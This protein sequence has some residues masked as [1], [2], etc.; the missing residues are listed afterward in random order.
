MKLFIPKDYL[1]NNPKPPRLFLCTTGK[2]II[3]E[4]PSYDESL[5]GKWGAYSEMQFSIDRQYV[6][7]LTGEVKVH[8]TFDKAEGLRKVYVENT[9][10]FVIQDPDTTYG[11]K[12]S[13]TLSCFS[14]EYETANKYLE[15]FRVNT[16]EI[17]SKEVIALESIYGYNYTIDKDNLYKKASGE[18]DAYESYYIKDYTDNN[19][20]V[21]EQVQIANASEY[22]TYDGSTVAKTLYVKAYPNVRFY[23]PTNPKLSLLHLVF[24][25]I[26]EWK[27]GEN[28]DTTLWRK[29]RTFDE[30]RIAVYDF[31]LNDVQETFKCVVEWDTITN[32]VNFYEEAEGGITEDNTVQTRWETD[33]FISREN[34]ANEININY[35]TDDIKT[36]LKVSGADNLDIREV[37]LGKN[38]ILNLDY[39]HTPDWME[40]DLFERYDDYLKAVEE[41]TPQYTEAMQNWVAAYNKWHDLMNAVPAEGNVVLVGDPFEKLYCVYGP[42]D[43]AYLPQTVTDSDLDK[44]VVDNLYSLKDKTVAIDKGTLKD[45]ETFAVQGYRFVYMKAN[46]NFKCLEYMTTYNERILVG[47]E[48]EPQKGKLS[49]YH[50]ID[51]TK[52]TE[53]DNILL[54]LK[55]SNS[56]IATIRIYN[57]GT[58]TKPEYIIQSII[59]GASSGIAEKAK[60]YTMTQWVKGELT[61]KLMGF[62][63]YTVQYIGTMGAYFVLAKDETQEATLEE[64]GVNLLKEKHNTYTTIFQTQTEAMFSQEKYQCIAQNEEPDGAY[65]VGTRWLD[66]NSS[67]VILKEYDGTKWNIISAT[68]SDTDQMNYENYQRYVDNYEKMVAVQHVLVRKEREATYCLEG[69]SVSA[70]SI[71]INLYVRD[72]DGILRYNG[73]TLEGDMHRAAESHFSGHTVVRQNMDQTLPVYTFTTSADPIIYGRNTEGFKSNI[74]YYI[75]TT[76]EPSITTYQEIVIENQSDFDSYDDLYVIVSGHTYALYLKGTTPYVA[77]ADSQA[78]HQTKKDWIARETDFEKFFSEDQWI[79][80]SPFI[81]EDEFSDSNFLLTGYESE[82]ERLE[83]CQELFESANK[84]LNTLCQPSL[85]FSMEMANI[86][87]LPEFRSLVDQFQLGNFVRVHIRD[88]YVKRARLLEVHLNFSDLSDFNCNFGNLVTTKSEID[89]HAELLSQAVTAG[90]QVATSAGDWQKAVDKSSRIEEEIANGLQNAALEVGRASGQSIVWDST[91]IWG[92]KLIDGTT[93]QYEDEQFRIINNKLVFSND[94]FKT[95]KSIMGRFVVKDDDGNDVTRWGLLAEAMVGGYIEGSEIRGGNLRIG[96]GSNNYFQVD[97]SGNVSI[98]QAGKEKYASVDAVKVIDDAYRYQIVLSYDKSTIFSN[99]EQDCTIT[100]TVYAFGA[101]ITSKVI[102]SGGSFSWTRVSSNATKDTEWNS[103]HIQTGTNANKVKLGVD[104]IET[105]SQFSCSV[106]FDE[107]KITT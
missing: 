98:V 89:K 5:D 28:I 75:K 58:K 27:I 61:A 64:Y 4:L 94:G 91:G 102:S 69:Y 97:E 39:Y 35:S 26:P 34:L 87:A 106:D 73:Q 67:P 56:D 38:Y 66:T 33:I 23:W 84:E 82:E 41:Y 79:R 12:D 63:G 96:D 9:G 14:S 50:V 59:V 104:D 2:K 53:S 52:G 37:N 83:I 78:V 49:L 42:I 16:G 62:E 86:L 54:R 24:E 90:K 31:L 100:C 55:N 20:Y 43:T 40:Q 105:N 57:K 77:Y 29:E 88:G 17:D 93:D 44:L 15:N 18:F 36:K 60:E 3:Q 22:A 13:K 101:D 32:T 76:E 103:A 51:D 45:Q 11:E 107:T 99:T 65:D 46:N 74:K 6:D 81:R 72:T 80:L 68:V 71:N 92:R 95:S 25:K 19:S 70:R 1:S 8:P 7:V 48:S 85:E 30:D 47:P 21:Y 10:Y